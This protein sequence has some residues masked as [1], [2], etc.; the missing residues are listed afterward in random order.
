MESLILVDSSYTSFY[1]FF[2]TLRWFSLNQPE[3]YKE[4]KQDTI[5]DWSENEIFIEKY[6]KMYLESIVKL[7][8]TKVYKKSKVIFCLDTPKKDLWR[9][10]LM[11]DYKAGR[12]DL[13][14]KANFK[15]TFDITYKTLIPHLVKQNPDKIYKLMLD[16][17][18][19]DDVIGIISKYYEE[20]EPTLPVY[21]VSGDNDFL[22]LGR[23]NLYICNYKNKKPILLSKEEAKNA[24]LDKILNGDCSDNITSIFVKKITTKKKKEMITNET[25]LKEYLKENKEA[26]EKFELNERLI[27]FNYI[28]TKLQS[29]LL[30]K[31][32]ELII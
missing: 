17:I 11:K 5:Y 16:K 29:L 31:F 27:D 20:K 6:K 19:A 7:V 32:K 4:K 13:S 3:I 26:K 2:A 10:E 24:L 9:N 23:P 1:R 22:Q 30:E 14:L 28:P 18:E 25:M 12:C 15:P 21:V 8:G